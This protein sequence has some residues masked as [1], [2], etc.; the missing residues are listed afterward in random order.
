MFAELVVISVAPRFTEMKFDP[1][2]SEIGSKSF[3]MAQEAVSRGV[4][5][6]KIR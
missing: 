5:N 6:C 1:M 2:F 3:L 4:I